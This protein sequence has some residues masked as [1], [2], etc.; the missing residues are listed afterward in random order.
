M[1]VEDRDRLFEKAL[2]RQLRS[3][4]AAN[5]AAC[6]D[7][8]T[9]AAYHERLLSA[10]EMSAAKNHLVSCGRCQEILAQLGATQDILEL[11]DR[12]K[13]PAM[14]RAESPANREEIFEELPAA[15]AATAEARKSPPNVTQLLAKKIP[16]KRSVVLRWAAPAGAIAAVLFLWIGLRTFRAPQQKAEPATQIAENRDGRYRPPQ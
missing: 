5:D 16:P 1:S 12:Q 13:A 15:V 4:P 14:L 6:L 9:L 8:E 7:A 3:G 11:Q 2:A 10:E